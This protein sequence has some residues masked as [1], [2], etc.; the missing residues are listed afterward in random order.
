[1]ASFGHNARNSN[2]GGKKPKDPLTIP[3]RKGEKH[4]KLFD[5]V[6]KH[7]CG[8]EAC[9]K[10][11]DHLTSEHPNPA[12][13]NLAETPVKEIGENASNQSSDTPSLAGST[14]TGDSSSPGTQA[15]NPSAYSAS[16]HH[17]G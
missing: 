1:M 13:G 12:N 2:L 5:G 10:W 8:R 15:D 6:M 9:R 7:W 16:I 4:S 11:G 17:F 3:P 14:I